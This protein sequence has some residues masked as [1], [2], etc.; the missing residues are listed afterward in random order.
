MKNQDSLKTKENAVKFIKKI[1]PNKEKLQVRREDG[2]KV[3][4]E[5]TM[6]MGCVPTGHD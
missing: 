6:A 1:S 2:K 4:V 5:K 3:T